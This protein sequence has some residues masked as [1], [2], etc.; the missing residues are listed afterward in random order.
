M[1]APAR[2]RGQPGEVLRRAWTVGG[3]RVCFA[4]NL[5]SGGDA[6]RFVAHILFIAIWLFI[7]GTTS[8]AAPVQYSVQALAEVGS[9]GTAVNNQGQVAGTLPNGHSFIYD[10]ALHD[11]GPN[12]SSTK[13]LGINSSGV[14]VGNSPIFG[15]VRAFIYDGTM[16]TFGTTYTSALA[17]NDAGLITGRFITDNPGGSTPTFTTA[18]SRALEALAVGSPKA[19]R[20][21]VPGKLPAGLI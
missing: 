15:E 20:S 3:A 14:V 13:A 12:G 5:I 4:G 11:L 7:G 6:I 1:A 18:P 16:Q 10:G 17:I 2:R 21:I 19:P 9:V 8:R